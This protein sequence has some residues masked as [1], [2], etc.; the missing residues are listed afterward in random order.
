LPELA[1]WGKGR[2]NQAVWSQDGKRLAAASSLGIYLYNAE[3]LEQLWFAESAEWLTSLA[4]SPDD[5]SLAS[6]GLRGTVQLWEA[7]SGQSL[8]RFQQGINIAR[9]AFNPDGTSLATTAGGDL[10]LWD[11]GNGELRETLTG[12]TGVI[13]SV[14][15]SPEGD[16]LASGSADGTVRLW[17]VSTGQT[18]HVLAG[19]TA[20]VNSVAFNPVDGS[21]LLASGSED[22]TVRLWDADT[23]ELVRIL[24]EPGQYVR[25]VAFSPDGGMLAS[26]VGGDLL[27]LWE[28]DTGQLVRS[29]DEQTGYV[30]GDGPLSFDLHGKMLVSNS[31]YGEVWVWDPASGELL[32]T[33]AGYSAAVNSVAFNPYDEGLTL[34]SGSWDNTAR[35]W[36]VMTGDLLHSFG[37]PT[38]GLFGPMLAGVIPW[39]GGWAVA[40][41]INSPEG[42]TAPNAWDPATGQLLHSPPTS[43]GLRVALL[44]SLAFSPDGRVLATRDPFGVEL[45]DIRSGQS[46]GLLEGDTGILSPAVFG[47]DGG[48]VASGGR[49][50]A[51]LIWEATTGELKLTLSGHE[52]EVESLAFGSLGERL[53]LASGSQDQTV[54]L[55]DPDTGEI[56][57]IFEGHEGAVT[58]LA[59]SPDGRLLASG[60]WDDSIRL[61]EASTGKLLYILEGHT[62]A[63]EGIAFSP[64]G[65]MLA[66]GSSDGTIRMWD[67]TAP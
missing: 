2:V 35:L 63:V 10:H 28:V 43:P 27:R 58:S 6:G 65:K 12:H 48:L 62:G 5:Q 53:V 20:T 42:P 44:G 49:D 51:V 40:A 8:R 7:D 24:D 22:Q 21:R 31:T 11:A 33:L 32:R 36:D 34:V 30:S 4:F 52:S 54:R 55:W 60:S 25:S 56:L 59:F 61:W 39:D 64:D 14:V 41:V 13:N 18:L 9:L 29:L 19:H 46:L 50:N 15:F 1:R 17:E 38:S 3:T 66:S 16:M 67:V 23:G 37:G 57:R 26:E 45:W 47:P